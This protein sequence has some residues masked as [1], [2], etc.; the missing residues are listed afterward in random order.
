MTADRGERDLAGL[1]I[2]LVG[3]WSFPAEMFRPLVGRLSSRE[4]RCHDWRGFADAWLGE[5]SA[6]PAGGIWLGWSLGGGLL[7]EAV[8]RGRLRPDRLLLVSA[9]PRFLAAGGWPGVPRGEWRALRRAARADPCSAACGFR[10]RFGLPDCHELPPAAAADP[11]GLDWLAA[12]DRRGLL[13]SLPNP[14]EVWLADD[15]PLIPSEWAERLTL[16]RSVVL[17]RLRGTGHGAIFESWDE[18]ARAL[19]P[20]EG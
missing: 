4:V 15:D 8:A 18:L 2:G 6:G 5:T 14:V 13:E 11:D 3:G 7:L 19:V 17:R 10:R 1:T 16:P 20:L 12:I 9:T